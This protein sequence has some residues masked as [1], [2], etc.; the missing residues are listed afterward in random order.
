MTLY[1]IPIALYWI[2]G[3]VAVVVGLLSVLAPERVVGTMKAM[4]L[5]QLRQV[6]SARYRQFL[7]INGWLSLV[8]GLAVLALLTM[9]GQGDVAN[10][11]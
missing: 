7:K 11:L 9:L 2:V 5:W 3:S 10:P 1:G 8:L 6:R 4:A